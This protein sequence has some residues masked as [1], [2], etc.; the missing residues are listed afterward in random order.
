MPTLKRSDL[1]YTYRWNASPEEDPNFMRY[2]EHSIFNR[3]E[4]YEVLY[5]INK[6]L[7]KHGLVTIG[8]GRKAEELIQSKLPSKSFTHIELWRWLK[9]NW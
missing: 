2:P 5:T 6:Y 1:L 3:S 9:I 4:G 8:D 7:E